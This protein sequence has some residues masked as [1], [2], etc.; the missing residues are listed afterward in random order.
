MPRNIELIQ[1][2]FGSDNPLP[3][4]EL[5]DNAL[6]L[7]GIKA[8]L[9]ALKSELNGEVNVLLG[10]IDDVLE[11]L[12]GH[13]NDDVRHLTQ[14]QINKISAAIN[15]AQALSIAQGAVNS[16]KPG[17]ISDAVQSC[18]TETERYSD[19]QLENKMPQI[20]SEASS[21]SIAYTD[22]KLSEINLPTHVDPET[23][24]VVEDDLTETLGTTPQ[25]LIN[26]EYFYNFKNMIDNS[27]FEVF[28]GNTLIPI[29]WDNGVV[30][31]DAS[32]F[33]TYSL[34]L[35]VGQT[36][37]Q[38]SGHLPDARW[39]SDVY[40]A[41]SGILCFYHKFNAVTVRVYDVVNEEYLTLTEIDQDLEEGDT[42]TSITFSAKSNWNRYRDMVKI[43]FGSGTQLIRVEFTCGGSNVRGCYIDAVSLEPY[44]AGKYPSIYKDGRYSVSAYQLL[45]PPPADVDRFTP[46]EHLNIDSTATITDSAGNVTTQEYDRTDGTLAIRRVATN[47]DQH[48]YYQTITETFYKKDGTT[49]NY[50]DT[51]TI[52]YSQSGAITA[53]TK[54]TTEGG[55]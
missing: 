16:A 2:Q 5:A 24:E 30:S 41:E 37:K 35:T 18:I 25:Y 54:T 49:E 43:D 13:E 39:F 12:R 15:A 29:G 22:Q 32:M 6:K 14:S 40:G 38:T 11:E 34:H 36:A 46:L 4:I 48:G 27:S 51:Y 31:A 8:D 28:D 10:N 7:G 44:D 33:S 50:T 52:T 55:L 47:P 20:I 9:Y 23:G 26:P 53:Q 17:I 3:S 21:E 1:K 42:G 45:N 19:Q